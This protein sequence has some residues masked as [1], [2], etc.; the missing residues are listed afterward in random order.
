MND[1][2][3][4]ARELIIAALEEDLG[5]KGDITTIAT[6]E[7]TLAGRAVI[8]A[9]Q[10]CVVAGQPIAKEVFLISGG[11]AVEYEI[12]AVDGSCLQPGEVVATMSGPAAA[13]LTAERTA[14]NFLAHLSGIATL[15]ASIVSMAAPYGV[16]ILD[17]RKTTPGL[18]SLE[19]YAVSVG[20]G[21]NHRKGLHDAILIKDNHIVASGG[22]IPAVRMAR[23]RFPTLP[24]EVEVTS[25]EEAEKALEAG[26]DVIMLDNMA[27][28]QAAEA[29]RLIGRRAKTEISGGITPRNIDDYLQT[30]VDSISLGFL[31]HSV[32]SCDL[33]LDLEIG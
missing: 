6:C 15:T 29:I 26:A 22:I 33:S 24:V 27:P 25:T 31:T 21:T 16:S 4:D 14:L 12:V 28:G 8:T 5:D 30:G 32:P 1:I 3:S 11:G 9:K 18:R 23:E 13:I 10:A 20:G 17:T 7:P 2:A 19:K